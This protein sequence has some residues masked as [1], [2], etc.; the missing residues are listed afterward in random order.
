MITIGMAVH[1]ISSREAAMGLGRQR[2]RRPAAGDSGRWRTI[3]RPQTIT[4]TTAA[5]DEAGRTGR[6]VLCDPGRDAGAGRQP[7]TARRPGQRDGAARRATADGIRRG[8]S[9][10]HLV[11]PAGGVRAPAPIP[12]TTRPVARGGAAVPTPAAAAAARTTMSQDR[13]RHARPTS[14]AEDPG[15][16]L[17]REVQ[18]HRQHVVAT[19][20]RQ[21][22]ANMREDRCPGRG[23]ERVLPRPVQQVVLAPVTRHPPLR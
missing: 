2:R 20:Q 15:E 1:T 3:V 11:E 17:D 10:L 16:R 5:I 22:P 7:A 14:A 12:R 4:A 19:R 13:D 9:R 18:E 21:R 6:A 23:A 8:S